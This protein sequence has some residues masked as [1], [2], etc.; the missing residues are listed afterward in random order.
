[1]L[2]RRDRQGKIRFTD[3]ST[4][5]FQPDSYG[6]T[7]AELMSSMHG[8]LPDGTWL[9]GVEVFRRLYAAVGFVRLA[10]LSRLPVVAQAL[11]LGYRVF[12]WNRLRLTGR[13]SVAACAAI[14][15][16]GNPLSL[17]GVT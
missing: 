1:M 6:K 16:D 10:A 12:A 5:A 4:A 14:G 8:R 2:Q 17:R 11:D 7:H 13:C 9:Q 3:I 15:R